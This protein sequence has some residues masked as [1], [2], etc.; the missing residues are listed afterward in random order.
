MSF[1][2][3]QL[4]NGRWI[5][6]SGPTGTEWIEADLVGHVEDYHGPTVDIPEPLEPYCDN[7][8][9]TDIKV[10]NGWG[11][12]L[13]APGYLDKTDWTVFETEEEAQEYLDEL[14]DDQ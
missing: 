5:E 8:Q 1:M 11:A 2:E 6:V 13:S 12:R 4:V 7:R 9:A 14:T 10:I 3:P